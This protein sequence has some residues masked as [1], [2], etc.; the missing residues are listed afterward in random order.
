MAGSTE[1]DALVRVIQIQIRIVQSVI[2]MM[3]VGAAQSKMQIVPGEGIMHR[4]DI[5]SGNRK[6]AVIRKAQP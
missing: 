3:Q 4:K 1:A 6:G 5:D 2:L